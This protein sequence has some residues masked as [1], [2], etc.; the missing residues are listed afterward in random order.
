MTN[1][2]DATNKETLRSPRGILST[3][4]LMGIAYQS[5]ITISDKTPKRVGC[6]ND[7]NGISHLWRYRCIGRV[8]QQRLQDGTLG[9]SAYI[10]S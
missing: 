9:W 5:P 6:W 7:E 3:R 1:R 8:H 2:I 10:D 4:E